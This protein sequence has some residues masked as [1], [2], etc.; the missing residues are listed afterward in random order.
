[1]RYLQ[2]RRYTPSMT[3]AF[4]KLQST[5]GLSQNKAQFAMRELLWSQASSVASLALAAPPNVDPLVTEQQYAK[6]KL[7]ISESP[8]FYKPELAQLLYPIF[9]HFYLD[10]VLAG[11]KLIAQKFH[12]RHQST[13]LVNPNFASFIRVLN[14][15]VN[16]EDIQQDNG[17]VQTFLNTKYSVTLSNR[18]FHYLMRY[19][20][21]QQSMGQ[22]H[23]LLHVLH[24]KVD[25]RLQDA[26][27]A[28]SSKL[29]AVRRVLSD[30]VSIN[31][32]PVVKTE[33]QKSEGCVTIKQEVSLKV[34][35]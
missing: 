11:H 31:P 9:T 28:P 12:K 24:A 35:C 29:E 20:Q 19:L 14:N 32:D 17:S 18:T 10:L 22:P 26:L 7:W 2:K 30:Q 3:E 25:V 6:F 4:Q 23:I 13:F 27:G 8:D 15:I 16:P 1:M 21:Q 33:T 34:E 5:Q